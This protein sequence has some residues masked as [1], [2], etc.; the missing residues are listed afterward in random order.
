MRRSLLCLFLVLS[1][2]GCKDLFSA[3]ANVAAEAAGLAE[4][5]V[6]MLSDFVAGLNGISLEQSNKQAAE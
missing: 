5:F 1:T 4:D 2:A 6:P 3:H